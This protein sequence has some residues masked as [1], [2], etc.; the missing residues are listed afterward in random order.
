MGQSGL[1][2]GWTVTPPLIPPTL[3]SPLLPLKALLTMAGVLP[4]GLTLLPPPFKNLKAPVR[5]AGKIIT[6]KPAA[7]LS[8]NVISVGDV[9]TSTPTILF[10]SWSNHEEDWC[11]N[12]DYPFFFYLII[13]DLFPLTHTVECSL[14]VFQITIGSFLLQLPYCS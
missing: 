8:S 10:V 6:L 4:P 12:L 11:Y 5:I 2:M 3:G 1:G 14:L 9:S 7:P 13:S